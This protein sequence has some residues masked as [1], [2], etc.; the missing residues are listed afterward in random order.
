MGSLSRIEGQEGD[1]AEGAGFDRSEEVMGTLVGEI[2]A[3][4]VS[5]AV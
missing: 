3:C 4:S 2:L 1:P 5:Q